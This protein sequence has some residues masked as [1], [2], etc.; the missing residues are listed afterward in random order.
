[1]GP[2]FMVELDKSV[3]RGF[4]QGIW[5]QRSR[6]HFNR[7]L[8]TFCGVQGVMGAYCATHPF[9]WGGG[10]HPHATPKSATASLKFILE[11]NVALNDHFQ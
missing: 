5:G 6:V 3:A 4:L 8:W 1:V 2:N 11:G 10:L 9:S 7:F